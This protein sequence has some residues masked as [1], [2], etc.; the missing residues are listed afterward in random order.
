MPLYLLRNRFNVKFVEFDSGLK[1]DILFR[2]FLVQSVV[3]Q[4]ISNFHT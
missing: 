2:V 4:L 3:R 1:L